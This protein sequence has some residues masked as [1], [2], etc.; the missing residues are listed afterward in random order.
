MKEKLLLLHG[1]LGSKKQFDSIKEV[2]GNTYDVYDM[3]FE[4]HGGAES[5]RDYSI[6]V[7]SENVIDFLETNSINQINI[8][9]YSMG[10]YVALHTALKVPYKIKKIIT[11]GTKFEWD[12]DSAEKETRMLNPLKIEE[13]VP[14]FAK[15][16]EKEHY[17]LDWK[18]IM[19]KTAAMMLDMGKGAK[20]NDNDFGRINQNVVIGVGSLDTMVS[21][22]ESEIVSELL[23]NSKLITLE[24]VEHPIN[25]IESQTIVDYIISNL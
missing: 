11:L 4:G 21:Y 7:F 3:N 12:L 13:K 1:A 16:L 6:E 25:K 10:G 14:H 2:L 8:F 23:P 22:E 17:P 9:G 15:M 5:Q 20:L 24:G 18:I 19:E